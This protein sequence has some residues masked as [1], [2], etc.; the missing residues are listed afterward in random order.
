[1]G[2]R[3]V[4]MLCPKGNK[5]L[6]PRGARKV[7]KTDCGQSKASLTVMFTFCVNG[8]IIPLFIIYPNKRR[9]PEITKSLLND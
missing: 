5:V 4:F 1:M 6:A 7:C 3:P 2:M 8:D 9:N